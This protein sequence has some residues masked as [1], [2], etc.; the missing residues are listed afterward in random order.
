[1]SDKV[2]VNLNQ[3]VEILLNDH[4]YNIL[5]EQHEALRLKVPRLGEFKEI[6]PN[7]DGL[8]PYETQLWDLFDRFGDYIGLGLKPPFGT[9]I[10]VHLGS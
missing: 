3:T 7:S 1:M 10:T 8:Y 6:E 4:G 2:T 5:K 9:D